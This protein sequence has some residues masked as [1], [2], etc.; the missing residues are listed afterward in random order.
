MNTSKFFAVA[1]LSLALA[2]GL[3]SGCGKGEKGR[4]GGRAAEESQAEP[5]AAAGGEAD[6]ATAEETWTL[7]EGTGSFFVGSMPPGATILIDGR[8]VVEQTPNLFAADPGH[9]RVSVQ[10]DGFTSA[11]DS[12]DIDV[13][14]GVVDSA[15]F[16]LRGGPLASYAL[17]E[18]PDKEVH[19]RWSP[20][21]STIVYEAYYG[22]NRDIYTIPLT[23]GEPT[24]MTFDERADFSPCWSPDGKE[25]VFTSN[26]GGTV[27]L[28]VIKAD[29]TE[30][31]RRLTTGGGAEENATFSP[32]GKWI[33]FESLSKIWKMPA[34][35]GDAIQVTKGVERHTFPSWSPDGKE[36]AFTVYTS[37]GGRQIWAV[38]VATGAVRKLISDKGWSYG[39]RWAPNGK[40]LVFVRR[41]APPERN[42]DLWIC[43]AEE[44]ELTQITMDAAPDLDPA[45]SPD[46]HEIVW[47][48]NG[49][50]W[51]MT[52]VPAWLLG[53]AKPEGS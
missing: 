37:A 16:R 43:S 38:N 44:G 22:G 51:V 6:S 48:K 35:G 47:S 40:V 1:A 31:P 13:T 12:I 52:N 32:D 34:G 36:I 46:G 11:P 5:G 23:G 9:Y 30:E 10:L 3:S 15:I 8:P 19:P 14:E 18:K 29:A 53:E 42:H 33:A 7:P 39:E 2:L 24:R 49:D 25:I 17:V 20:D 4:Q 41:G 26:R 27:D 45:W 28:W 21:G 50:L